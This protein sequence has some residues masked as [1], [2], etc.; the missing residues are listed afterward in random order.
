MKDSK[1]LSDLYLNSKK[2]G[3][4]ETKAFAK[5]KTELKNIYHQLGLSALIK[6]ISDI[7]VACFT[8][9]KDAEVFAKGFFSII[10]GEGDVVNSEMCSLFEQWLL[11]FPKSLLLTEMLADIYGAVINETN[12]VAYTKKLEELVKENPLLKNA[13]L[14]QSSTLMYSHDTKD[15]IEYT[16]AVEKIKSFFDKFPEI[17]FAID[18]ANGLKYLTHKQEEEEAIQ[19][20]NKL[21]LLNKNWNNHFIAYEYLNALSSLTWKQDEKACL[22]T[23]QEMESLWE[24]WPH[25]P[26]NLAMWLCYTYSNYSLCI[27]GE[28]KKAV[29]KRVNELSVYWEPASRMAT[30][31]EN[32]NYQYAVK[33]ARAK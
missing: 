14:Q 18:Y 13:A 1:Q 7:S 9:S 3:L 8:K 19:S 33:P 22:A 30:Q 20:V 5:I 2:D 16:K 24:N 23:L 27:E 25:K 28:E 6:T 17:E 11:M 32:G 10:A 29:A 21:R 31:I 15:V 4:T 12:D 26:E